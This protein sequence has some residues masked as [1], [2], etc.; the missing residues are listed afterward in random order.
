MPSS[1][2]IHLFAGR[3]SWLSARLSPRGLSLWVRLASCMRVYHCLKALSAATALS[4]LIQNTKAHFS[5]PVCP[6]KIQQ[7]HPWGQ[8]F[9][10]RLS[11]LRLAAI[12]APTLKYFSFKYATPFHWHILVKGIINQVSTA[13]KRLYLPPYAKMCLPVELLA[14]QISSKGNCIK[15]NKK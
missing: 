4:L 11:R 15:K 10:P 9:L 3:N 14:N 7:T 13:V 2:S 12:S 5:H 8:W 6:H 1:P